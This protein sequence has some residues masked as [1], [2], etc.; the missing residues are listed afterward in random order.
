[1]IPKSMSRK[2]PSFGQ[3]VSYMSSE[4]A[5]DSFDLY[6]N[7]LAR[8]GADITDAFTANSQHLRTRKNG[9]YLYHE[10][11]SISLEQGVERTHAKQCLREIA[12]VYISQRCPRNMVYGC[13]H[14]DHADH[15]HYHL[16]ISANEQHQSARLRLTKA[17]FDTIKRDLETHVL[18]NYPELKQRKIVTADRD[19]KKTSH[20][21]SQQKRR[22]GKLERQ[23]AVR[24][25]IA[26]A[27]I[28]TSSLEDFKSYLEGKRYQFYT[29]GK[30][31]GV[32]VIHD[33]G[34][35][36]RYRFATIGVHDDFELY[37]ASLEALTEAQTA[38]PNRPQE[39]VEQESAPDGASEAMGATEAPSDAR[40]DSEEM[41]EEMGR[42]DPTQPQ[43][44]SAA[45]DPRKAAEKQDAGEKEKQ[46]KQPSQTVAQKSAFLREM[47]KIYAKR[48]EKKAQKRVKK[49]GRKPR[50][51]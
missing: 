2:T 1:M 13:L 3:L 35:V 26:E 7:C 45:S 8:G 12:L 20:K 27:M 16:M 25:T 23:E 48:R 18:E 37:L 39:S 10:I 19:E 28:H 14:D 38:A 50:S 33:T 40:E 4:K 42:D 49:L 47:E 5:D 51:R 17:K 31:Y 43:P 30:H 9:N 29:R 22:T 15:L 6:Q 11:L 44:A 41:G 46:A 24:A 36:A 34:K 21:A 32:E